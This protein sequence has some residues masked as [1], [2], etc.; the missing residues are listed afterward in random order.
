MDEPRLGLG[1][2]NNCN[3]TVKS[4]DKNMYIR[5]FVLHNTN[6]DVFQSIKVMDQTE[7]YEEMSLAAALQ[8]RK[9]RHFRAHRGRVFW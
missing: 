9:M 7:S 6:E 8:L 4:S 3:C 5:M 2:K 1:K